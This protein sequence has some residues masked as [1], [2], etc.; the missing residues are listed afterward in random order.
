M[1]KVPNLNYDE[2]ISALRR[3]GWAI[4]RPKR[5]PV[6]CYRYPVGASNRSNLAVRLLI[7]PGYS[8]NAKEYESIYT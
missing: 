1:S 2:L 4:V 7:A 6:F 8:M 5:S 3:Y